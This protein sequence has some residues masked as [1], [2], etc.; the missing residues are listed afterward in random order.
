MF[1]GYVFSTGLVE[2]F[3]NIIKG[4][5]KSIADESAKNI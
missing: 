4:L 5:N 2:V 1:I 3:I